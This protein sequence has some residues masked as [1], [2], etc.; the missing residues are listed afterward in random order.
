MAYS[1]NPKDCAADRIRLMI[2]DTLP[3]PILDDETYEYLLLKYKNENKAALFAGQMVMFNLSRYTRERTGDI[4]VYGAEYFNNYRKALKDWL[5]NP[6]FGESV[7]MPYAGGISRSDMIA[8]AE[9]TDTLK[10]R[11]YRD[12]TSDHSIYDHKAED[13]GGEDASY[14]KY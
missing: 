1:G 14:F 2:G 6:N 9:D 3:Q 10:P 7:A 4:E 8:N 12:F 11:A 13:T 5:S